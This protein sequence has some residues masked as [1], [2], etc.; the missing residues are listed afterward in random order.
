MRSDWGPFYGRWT[1]VHENDRQKIAGP[2]YERIETPEGWHFGALRPLLASWNHAGDEV[3]RREILWPVAKQSFRE[4]QHVWRF[5][6]AFGLNR[7]VNDPGSR[8]RVWVFPVYFQGRDKHG[9]TYLAVFP[10]GGSLHEFLLWDE[11]S[12]TLFPLYVRS[13]VRDVE[14]ESWVWPVFSRTEGDAVRRGRVFPFYGYSEREGLG[15]KEFILW[16]F[17]T[18]VEYT[19]PRMEGRG[20]ILF[21][22]TGHLETPDQESW[23]ILPPFFRYHVGEEKNRLFG[24]WPFVQVSKGATDK[25]YLWPLYG[26][27]T[28]GDTRRDFFLWPIGSHETHRGGYT[29]KTRTFVVPVYQSFHEADSETGETLRDY[30]KVWPLFSHSYHREGPARRTVFPDLNPF[31][32]GPIERNW[33]PFWH[34]Y[35]REQVG[36]AVDTEILWGFYRSLKREDYRYR[37][38]F[39]LMSVE[40]GDGEREVNLLKGLLGWRREPGNNQLRLLYFLRFGGRSTEEL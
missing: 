28:I 35:R 20:W 6:V 16:P 1:D 8:Y 9:E 22:I 24:P 39:P 25:F 30:K 5:L 19:H 18:S 15:R 14:A 40:S 34:L 11:I 31:R 37:S 33:A 17:W 21:P 13:R 7:D 32:D 29:D 2:V 10:F 27:K 26:R 3:H 36:E 12:F 38:L 4:E 23:W